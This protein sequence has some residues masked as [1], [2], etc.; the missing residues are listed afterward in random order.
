MK[1][2]GVVTL[3]AVL[4]FMTVA[5]AAG[6]GGGVYINP[7]AELLLFPFAVAGT[8]TV[9]VA[10]LL[11]APF[12]YAGAPPYSY[13]YTYAAPVSVYAAPATPAPS[14]WYYCA[15]ARK[16]YPYVSTCPDGWMQVVPRVP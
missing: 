1:S 5:P 8:I 6:Q 4:M 9:G 3:T 2:I 13:P 12:A 11:T 10:A 7:L 15:S 14:Y 16:Y